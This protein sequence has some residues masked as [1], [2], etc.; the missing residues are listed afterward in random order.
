MFD[1]QITTFLG[2]PMYTVATPTMKKLQPNDWRIYKRFMKEVKKHCIAT[3]TLHKAK[4][5]YSTAQ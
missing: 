1:F 4:A 2:A 5:H 3:G